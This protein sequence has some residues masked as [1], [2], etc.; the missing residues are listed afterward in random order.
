[1]RIIDLTARLPTEAFAEE[2]YSGTRVLAPAYVQR[3]GKRIDE[4]PVEIFVSS[5][6]VLDLTNLVSKEIDDEHLEAAE[7]RAGLSIREGEAVI[8][9]T[10]S[11]EP[12]DR[13]N[14]AFLSENG[15]AFLEFK[16][17]SIVGT[18]APRLDSPNNPSLPVHSTLLRA[19]IIVL[20]GLCNLNQ[21]EPFRFRLI[22]LPLKLKA[23][24]SPVRAIA[25]LGD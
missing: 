9:N 11:E 18:D 4:L 15:V 23:S 25:I 19:G 1:M 22:A 12:G 3:G 2:G 13:S 24:S 7:E 8:L 5:A 6:V 20:E 17:P 14:H 10:G 16:H 21:I